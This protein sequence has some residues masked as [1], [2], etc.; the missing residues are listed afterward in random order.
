MLFCGLNSIE[1]FETNNKEQIK[2]NTILSFFAFLLFVALA[3]IAFYAW[4]KGI[5]AWL[6]F[7]KWILSFF[8][9]GTT[10]TPNSG[11]FKS[12]LLAFGIIQDGR[13]N[14]EKAN[15]FLKE[16]KKEAQKEGQNNFPI[17]ID[18]PDYNKTITDKELRDG[19][20][21]IP[22]KPQTRDEELKRLQS[23]IFGTSEGWDF[24]QF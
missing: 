21:T 16:K 23:Q 24:W 14:E 7:K 19:V 4:S 5:G 13:T 15:D 11:V 1:I 20:I 8:G 18:K 6:D 22:P 12:L 3:I 10:S 17:G 2:L 9:N